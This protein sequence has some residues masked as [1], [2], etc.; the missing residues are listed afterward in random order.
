MTD[1]FISYSRKDREFANRLVNRLEKDRRDVWIDWQ[2]IPR[3]E[4][5]LNEIKLG[6]EGTNTFILIIT[7]HSITSEICNL[8]IQYAIEHHKRIV[9]VIR[10]P[11]GDDIKEEVQDYW[12]QQDWNSIAQQNWTA[13]EHINWIFADKT[14]DSDSFMNFYKELIEAVETDYNHVRQHTRYQLRALDWTRSQDNPSLLLT[15]DE[16]ATA[17]G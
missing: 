16:I 6:I 7:R 13:L 3:G 8:E 1:V 10:E 14:D 11:I 2:D 5:W 12:K 15:G 17:E 4:Q 9:P